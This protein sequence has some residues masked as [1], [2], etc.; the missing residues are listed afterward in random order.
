MQNNNNKVQ[1]YGF[2]FLFLV[3]ILIV[4][5]MFFPFFKTLALAGIFAILLYPVHLEVK[6]KIRNESLASL[7]STILFLVSVLLPLWLV[8]QLMFNELVE[9]YNKFKFGNVTFSP[10][11]FIQK[12][13]PNLQNVAQTLSNDLTAMVSKITGDA[14]A[15][16]SELLSNLVGF[17]IATFLFIFILFYFF[18]DGAK[19]REILTKLSPLSAEYESLL[20]N[21]LE[22]A[23]VGVLKGSFLV[24]L[25]QGTTATIA[26]LVLGMPQPLLWGAATALSSLVPTVGTSITMIPAIAYLWFTGHIGQAIALAVWGVVV[27][28]TIDNVVGP[29]LIGTQ[30]KLHPML[31]LLSILGGVNIFGFLGVF[32][33]PI[34]VAVFVALLEIYLNDLKDIWS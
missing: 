13:P 10:H 2:L 27:V 18:R 21:K 23:I 32:F 22:L 25:I 3:F 4:A 5:T 29:K 11:E 31:V 14:F 26:Y 12:L 20:F 15:L 28:S 17:F 9:V 7:V 24:S 8:G 1:I 6:K 34:I 16:I 19:I 30:T 33:G